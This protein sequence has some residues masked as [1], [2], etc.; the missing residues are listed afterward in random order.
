MHAATKCLAAAVAAALCS[1]VYA[2]SGTFEGTAMGKNDQIKVSVELKEDR[3]VS[4]KVGENYET[5]SISRRVF[6]VVPE[7]IVDNQTVNVDSIS[8]ATF[9]S[10]GVLGAVRDAL[11]KSGT[12]IS[13]FTK[14]PRVSEKITID[15]TPKADVVIIGGGG[16]GLSAAVTAARKGA[17]VLILEKSS[18]VGGNTMAAGGGFN[19]AVPETV[20]KHDMSKGQADLIE[21]QL[22]AKPL[23]EKQAEL[24]AQLAEDWKAYKARGEKHADGKPVL[25]DSPAWHA[26]QTWAAGDNK[27]DLNLVDKLSHLAPESV[28]ILTDMG[29]VWNDKTSQY[30]GALW[31]RSHDA[32]NYKSGEGFIQ[33]FLQTIAKEKL[34]VKISYY[35]R[36]DNLVMKDGRVVGVEAKGPK[37]EKMFAS[38]NKGVILATGGFSANIEMR[39]KYDT[40]WG[41]LDSSIPTTNLS[42]ITGDG[43]VMAEKLGANL[44]GMEYIQLLPICDPETGSVQTTVSIGTPLYVNMEGKRFVNELER[45]DVISKAILEQPGKKFWKVINAKNA[46]IDKNGVNSYGLKVETLIKQGK[47]VKADTVEELAQKMGVPADNLVKTVKAWNEFCRK[48]VDEEFGRPSCLDNVTLFEGPYYADIHSPAVHHTMGGVQIDTSTHVIDKNGKPIPGLYAAG[49]VTGG[50]HGTNRVGAN[51]IPDALSFGRVAGETVVNENK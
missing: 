2:A 9:T 23:N 27:A 38:A 33:T 17:S 43:I 11:K 7:L 1:S 26:L 13:K 6:K 28:K 41:N 48:Q 31:P 24:I 22:A 49:E 3:I 5:P 30:V 34:P 19:A 20:A 47:V 8:G 44:V 10:F 29:L 25:F 37:G 39:M 32:A 4:V 45:R 12:D 18:F 40:K 16:A 14:G 51:A 15:P 42:G 50:I 21:A 46:R 35:T 36:A